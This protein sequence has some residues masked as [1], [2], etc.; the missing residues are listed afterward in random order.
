MASPAMRTQAYNSL[1]AVLEEGKLVLLDRK[2]ILAQ[3]A[4]FKASYDSYG[5]LRVKK[6]R[7]ADDLVDALAVAVVASERRGGRV[8]TLPRIEWL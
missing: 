2:D 5:N 7:A 8:V 1:R 4:T 6:G 3:F